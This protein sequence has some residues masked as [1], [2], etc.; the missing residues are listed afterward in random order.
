MIASSPRTAARSPGGPPL[1]RAASACCAH[2]RDSCEV[3]AGQLPAPQLVLDRGGSSHVLFTQRGQLGEQQSLSFCVVAQLPFHECAERDRLHAPPGLAGAELAEH[4]VQSVAAFC[5]VTG[6]AER[7]RQPG[8]QRR[9]LL[10]RRVP[11][12]KQPE[13]RA[14]PLCGS[15]GCLRLDGARGVGQQ[16][17]RPQIT[18]VGRPLDVMRLRGQ[19]CATLSQCGCGAAVCRDPPGGVRALIDG[20]PDEGMAEGEHLGRIDRAD[21]IRRGQLGDRGHRTN[22]LEARDLRDRHGP[23]RVADHRRRTRRQLPSRR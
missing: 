18:E 6:D 19:R 15:G 14:E 1:W 4:R 20:R 3:A 10:R 9:P 5:R 17:H 11:L 13:R 21:Q 2:L 16:A 22:L 23:E 12:G 7:E 8:Q